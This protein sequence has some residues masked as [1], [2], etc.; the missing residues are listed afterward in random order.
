MNNVRNLKR[1]PFTADIL[2]NG[3]IKVTAIDIS[4]GGLFVH[5]G[6][7]DIPGKIVE[8]A[9]PF[10][11]DIIKVR[12]KVQHSQAG[13]GMGL[14]FVNLDMAQKRAVRELIDSLQSGDR[15]PGEEAGQRGKKE[16]LL[17]DDN[18]STQRIYKSRLVL[19]GFSVT[20]VSDG[21]EAIKI[22]KT[23]QSP[24]DIIVLDLYMDKIDG[25]KV[26]SVLKNTSELKHIPVVILSS[27]NSTD[28]MKK[29]VEKGADKYLAKMNTSPATLAKTIAKILHHDSRKSL[30]A[31]CWEFTGC[32]RAPGGEHVKQSGICPAS[33]E[34]RLN[35]LH[36]GL[37]AGRACWAI[38][39]TMCGGKV[40]S[41]FA[42]KYK[43]CVTCT[44]YK[45]VREEEDRS[46][47]DTMFLLNMLDQ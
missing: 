6:R 9:I 17:I 21:F 44:F 24:T 3:E 13:I 16:V 30:K 35:D 8:V 5:T 11:D 14:M 31:N 22:L 42:Q 27:I 47:Q 45:K 26:L 41:T 7:A 46:Y 33:L 2:V 15:S 29:A 1:V 37:N 36:G 40:Q 32:G 25:F 28:I 10:D 12:A 34:E 18:L 38:V 39:G 43:T 19:E 20:A 23:R 4:E